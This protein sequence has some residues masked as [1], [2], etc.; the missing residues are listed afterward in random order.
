M[1]ENSQLAGVATELM[2]RP[3][4]ERLLCAKRC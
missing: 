3:P 4:E 2:V 1:M